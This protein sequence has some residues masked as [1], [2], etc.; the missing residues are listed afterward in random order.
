M[1]WTLAGNL[2][3]A[4]QWN[5]EVRNF[6]KRCKMN[7]FFPDLDTRKVDE[8]AKNVRS[9]TSITFND[10]MSRSRRLQQLQRTSTSPNVIVKL[11]IQPPYG[12]LLSSSCGELQPLAASKE[13]FGPKADFARRTNGRTNGQR[14]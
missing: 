3:Y 7:Y 2:N 10:H 5:D 11:D 9:I 4:D 1:T 13:P 14:V 12:E 6:S 8:L